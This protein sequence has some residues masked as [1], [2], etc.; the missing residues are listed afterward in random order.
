M[1]GMPGFGPTHEEAKLCSVVAFLRQLPELQP[2]AY[3]AMV[4][5]TQAKQEKE[6]GEAGHQHR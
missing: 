2:E 1:T 3:S 6:G 5:S 4:Q